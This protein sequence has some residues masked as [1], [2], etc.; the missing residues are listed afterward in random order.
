MNIADDRN[1][2][3]ILVE[4]TKSGVYSAYMQG[5]ERATGKYVWLLGDDDYPLDAA[6]RLAPAM[7]SGQ[8][9][10]LVGSVLLSNGKIYRPNRTLFFLILRNWCQ[11]GIVYRRSLLL[12]YGFHARFKVQADHYLNILLRANDTI[13]KAYLDFPVCVFG[14][15]GFSSRH[16]DDCFRRVRPALAKRVLGRVGYIFFFLTVLPASSIKRYFRR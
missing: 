9:D 15:S 12:Q 8:V 2:P 7:I 14:T 3:M 6:A 5:I 10:L 4:E 13:S 16:R 11:Q 1:E